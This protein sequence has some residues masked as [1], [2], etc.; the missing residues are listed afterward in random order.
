MIG[1]PGLMECTVWLCL[2]TALTP[3]PA[4]NPLSSVLLRHRNLD[5]PCESVP[6]KVLDVATQ[7]V[8]ATGFAAAATVAVRH[9]ES[10]FG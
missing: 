3:H 7:E 4:S 8:P 9:Q 6:P 5:G 1:F 2:F 10:D